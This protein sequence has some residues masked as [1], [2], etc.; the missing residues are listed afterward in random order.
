MVFITLSAHS[1]V[2]AAMVAPSLL[3]RVIPVQAL[4]GI[5]EENPRVA[6]SKVDNLVFIIF[7]FKII[8]WCNNG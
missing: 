5:C 3:L 6:R 1:M 2:R 7:G 4:V 8:L